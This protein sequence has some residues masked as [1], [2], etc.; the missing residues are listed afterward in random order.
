MEAELH[1]GEEKWGSQAEA[2]L[3]E[4]GYD[5]VL[6]DKDIGNAPALFIDEKGVR[7][8]GSKN[9]EEFLN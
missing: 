7:L 1:T 2:S 5:V 4:M 9:I 6:I 3:K 8:R